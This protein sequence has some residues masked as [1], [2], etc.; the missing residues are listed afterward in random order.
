MNKV[1]YTTLHIKLP[2]HTAAGTKTPCGFWFSAVGLVHAFLPLT[3]QVQFS[4]L[5]S[6]NHLIPHFPPIFRKP[7][8][9]HSYGFPFRNLPSSFCFF[10]LVKMS[11]PIYPLCSYAFDSLFLLSLISPIHHYLL[12]SIPLEFELDHIPFL[13]LSFEYKQDLYIT[14]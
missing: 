5:I 3:R 12:F 4:L 1:V 14:Y 8:G 6:F 13:I 11:P 10:H 7:F 2:P 9:S